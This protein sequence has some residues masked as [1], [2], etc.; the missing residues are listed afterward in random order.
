MEKRGNMNRKK[1]MEK[2]YIK[3]QKKENEVKKY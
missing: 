3:F 2:E 1:M